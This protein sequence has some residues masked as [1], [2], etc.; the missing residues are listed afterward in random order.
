MGGVDT[1]VHATFWFAEGVGIVRY[2]SDIRGVYFGWRADVVL[3]PLT[4]AS[5]HTRRAA[6]RRIQ[7][8]GSPALAVLLRVSD[9]QVVERDD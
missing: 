5:V 8:R 9:T 6:R 1:V 4:A 2:T 3:C 7:G